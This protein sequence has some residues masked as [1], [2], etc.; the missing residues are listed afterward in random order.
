[1]SISLSVIAFQAI[2]IIVAIP[3]IPFGIQYKIYYFEYDKT[4]NNTNQQPTEQFSIEFS[5]ICLQQ[6]TPCPTDYDPM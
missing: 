3:M 4:L 6:F 2:I 5:A 1:M